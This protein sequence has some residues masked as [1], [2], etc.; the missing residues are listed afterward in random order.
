VSHKILVLTVVEFKTNPRVRRQLQ[1][2]SLEHQI[3]TAGI[4]ESEFNFPHINLEVKHRVMFGRINL[5]ALPRVLALGLLM[6]TGQHKLAELFFSMTWT[7]LPN[8]R[9]SK[10]LK[11]ERVSFVC[12]HDVQTVG[13]AKQLVDPENI[14]LDLPEIA[15]FQ[16]ENSQKWRILWGRHFAFQTNMA[17][18]CCSHFTTVSSALQIIFYHEFG[19]RPELLPNT[20]P[21]RDDLK[22]SVSNDGR[23]QL[24]HT[25]AAIS[26]RGLE[27]M[28]YAVS[29]FPHLF[30]LDMYLTEVSKKYLERL[31][32]I[33]GA[34]T[35]VRILSPV[36]QN[37]LVDTINQYD[38]SI[39]FVNPINTNQRFCLPNKLF[40][41]IQAR[42]PVLSGPTPDIAK[43]INED[44]IGWVTDGFEVSDIV[45]TLQEINR[46]SIQNLLPRM[47]EA[48]EK[49]IERD[50]SFAEKLLS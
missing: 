21:R 42:V 12:A 16:N 1:A 5:L 9:V 14:W 33:A 37:I 39:I 44:Q 4:G 18:D 45:K 28:I 27:L 38:I 25:G 26:S 43:I 34:T 3:V 17:R 47:E 32:K 48:A 41:S 29:K 31:R 10:R 50:Y 6:V 7:S 40:D 2:L 15:A 20:S 23:I 24:V 35:N 19:I 13:L 8:W 22:P 36:S 30:N 46:E 49:F 11:R